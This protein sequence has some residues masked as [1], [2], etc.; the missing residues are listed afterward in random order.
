MQHN[1]QGFIIII[2]NPRTPFMGLLQIQG[3][4]VRWANLGW[5]GPWQ[6]HSLF[7]HWWYSLSWGDLSCCVTNCKWIPLTPY[8]RI[9]MTIIKR[10]RHS[11]T[12][13]ASGNPKSERSSLMKMHH[14][15]WKD[16]SK[17]TWRTSLPQRS[18][19]YR[20]HMKSSFKVAVATQKVSWGRIST[21]PKRSNFS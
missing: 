11:Q 21:K 12:M 6:H 4:R 14:H 19:P 1:I 10:C 2:Y 9:I 5:E 3:C 18:S 20:F 15:L 13:P 7:V 16:R 8:S 17:A